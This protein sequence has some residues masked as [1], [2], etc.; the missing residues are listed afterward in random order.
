MKSFEA[1]PAFGTA[2]VEYPKLAIVPVVPT[3]LAA[4]T[5]PERRISSLTPIASMI[6]FICTHLTIA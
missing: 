4:K 1:L 5:K 3:T 2:M 6:S